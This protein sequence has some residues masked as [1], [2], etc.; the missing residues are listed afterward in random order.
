MVMAPDIALGQVYKVTDQLSRTKSSINVIFDSRAIES[1]NVQFTDI[2]YGY[3]FLDQPIGADVKFY[4]LF[5]GNVS[6]GRFFHQLTK[7]IDQVTELNGTK[8]RLV[9]REGTFSGTPASGRSIGGSIKE[10]IWISTDGKILVRT[11]SMITGSA[12]YDFLQEATQ[13]G[14]VIFARPN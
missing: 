13:G 11:I 1:S 6:S 5:Q 12:K 10:V 9:R 3:A 2:S 7:V 14:E 8:I 4:S